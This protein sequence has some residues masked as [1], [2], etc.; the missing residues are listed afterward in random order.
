MKIFKKRKYDS[1][2]LNE[3]E[4]GIYINSKK[5]VQIFFVKYI[6]LIL[7]DF[8]MIEKFFDEK[9]SL[10]IFRK[11]AELVGSLHKIGL[12]HTNLELDNFLLDIK[13]FHYIR[14]IIN[15]NNYT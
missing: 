4:K 6:T 12:I 2:L 13:I 11:I 1:K 10:I 7:N 3:I 9:L 8:L 5:E 15:V 14:N